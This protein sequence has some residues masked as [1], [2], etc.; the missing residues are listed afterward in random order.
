MTGTALLSTV[1]ET[2]GVI[3]SIAQSANTG[4]KMLNDL[5]N[6]AREQQLLSIKYSRVGYENILRAQKAQEIDEA[7]QKLQDY[8]GD[9]PAKAERIEKI[10]AEFDKVQA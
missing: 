3:T 7:Q 8:I 10:F 9:D 4:A 2:A 5:A 6:N 1:T